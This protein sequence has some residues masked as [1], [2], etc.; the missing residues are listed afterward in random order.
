[1]MGLDA[2]LHEHAPVRGDGAGMPVEEESCPLQLQFQLQLP[3]QGRAA[4]PAS[5]PGLALALAPVGAGREVAVRAAEELPRGTEPLRI[6]QTRW[7]VAPARRQIIAGAVALGGALILAG[8]L[9]LGSGGKAEIR[10]MSGIATRAGAVTRAKA[11]A[12][13]GAEVEAGTEATASAV[14]ASEAAS[15]VRTVAGARVGPAMKQASEDLSVLVAP[16]VAKKE[17]RPARTSA[18][19]QPSEFDRPDEHDFSFLPT[20]VPA[21]TGELARSARR[22]APEASLGD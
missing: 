9:A 16:L 17:A 3:P 21:P 22:A 11:A 18:E 1:M 6:R 5:A 2:D 8:V 15:K 20:D 12:G 14:R 19:S 4:D 13:A 7:A 10:S